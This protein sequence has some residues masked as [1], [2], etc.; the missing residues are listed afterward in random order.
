MLLT[1][2]DWW[3]G[4]LP[5]DCS[6]YDLLYGACLDNTESGSVVSSMLNPAVPG[7]HPDYNVIMSF[8]HLLLIFPLFHFV[9]AEGISLSMLPFNWHVN[10]SVW[11]SSRSYAGVQRIGSNCSNSCTTT[12]PDGWEEFEG[13]CFLWVRNNKTSWDAAEKFCQN[14][15]GHLV[16]VTSKGVQDYMLD[17]VGRNPVWIGATDRKR[18]GSWEW[19]DCSHFNFTGWATGEPSRKGTEN[20]LQLHRAEK[21]QQ[22]WND[23]QCDKLLDFV[24]S[25]N[26]CPGRTL[27]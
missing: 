15:G 13:K 16:S 17:R 18:E 10:C 1:G 23:L 8:S 21:H 11:Q 3:K 4:T 19:S 22:G 12:C 5:F 2:L 14:Q 7:W 24:C 20:C 6:R 9:S 25:I 27:W 26:I